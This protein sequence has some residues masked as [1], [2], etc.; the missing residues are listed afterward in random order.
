MND[1]TPITL[2]SALGIKPVTA[3]F[4]F[5]GSIVSLAFSKGVTRAQAIVSFFVGFATALGTTAMVQQTLHVG[6]S[7]SGGV[8]FVIG[9]TAMRTL[10]VVLN[11]VPLL[12]ARWFG[13][14][15]NQPTQGEGDAK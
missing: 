12:T 2:L 5:L 15:Q 11:A 3:F 9:L 14:P 10:P 7:F 13:N 4:G 1:Q 6:D 8:S